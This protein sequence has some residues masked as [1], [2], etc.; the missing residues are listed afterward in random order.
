[1]VVVPSD[2]DRDDGAELRGSTDDGRQ[3]AGNL[4]D[5]AGNRDER[6]GHAQSGFSRAIKSIGE[7]HLSRLHGRGTIAR[8]RQLTRVAEVSPVLLLGYAVRIHSAKSMW[9]ALALQ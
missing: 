4:C 9:S 5:A 2:V 1:M 7:V 6:A 3:P 8:V